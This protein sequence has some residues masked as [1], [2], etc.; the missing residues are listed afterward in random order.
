MLRLDD[1]KEWLGLGFRP[2]RIY[3]LERTCF[4]IRYAELAILSRSCLNVY[5]PRDGDATEPDLRST[6]PLLHICRIEPIA[7]G[8]PAGTLVRGG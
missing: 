2:F 4:E 6:I 5:F 7:D 1:F 8:F 3:L